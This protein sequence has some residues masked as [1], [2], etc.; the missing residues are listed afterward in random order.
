MTT[1]NEM[2]KV[3]RDFYDNLHWAEM[4][5]VMRGWNLATGH[6][7]THK[8]TAEILNRMPKHILEEEIGDLKKKLKLLED[9][10]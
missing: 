8:E 3:Q 6:R 5:V 10:L 4:A 9:Y 7:L 1:K 2:T